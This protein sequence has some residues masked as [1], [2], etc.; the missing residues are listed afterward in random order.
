[1]NEDPALSILDLIVGTCEAAEALGGRRFEVNYYNGTTYEDMEI[2]AV[3]IT[4]HVY[5]CCSS[6][7]CKAPGADTADSKYTTTIRHFSAYKI[8][9]M[10]YTGRVQ[11]SHRKQRLNMA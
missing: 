9:Y 1:M 4:V 8:T 2:S 11:G 5:G 6:D 7:N 3:N 10:T